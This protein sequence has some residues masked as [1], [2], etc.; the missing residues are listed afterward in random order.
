MSLVDHLR[1]LIFVTVAWIAFVII[2]LP[3]YYQDWPFRKLLY[4]CVFVYFLVGFFILMMTKKYEG[5]FLRR[6]LW[7]AFYITV[8]LM[9]YDIIYVDLIRHEPFDLLNRFWYL[10]VF[11]IVP[12]IQAPLI[13]FF[14]VSGSL[15]KRNWIILSMISLVLAVI[16]YN[17]WGT[18]EGGFFDYMSSYPERNI[19]ML[20]SAL[21]LSILGTVISVAVLSMYR[22]IK[23]LVRW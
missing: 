21:R 6:A 4:F 14:L 1:L 3:N 9:I 13:Y 7:V 8:P 17:F 23:L 16:L 12:W 19:T 2:G 15:R 18:F 11:Y 5:Y 20:D 22:F 10:S